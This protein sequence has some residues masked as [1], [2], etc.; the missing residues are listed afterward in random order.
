M[1][2][3]RVCNSCPKTPHSLLTSWGGFDAVKPFAYT[4]HSNEVCFEL[5]T[6]LRESDTIDDFGG[7]LQPVRECGGTHYRTSVEMTA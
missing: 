6:K 2:S 3:N 5:L 1:R 4:G 7:L